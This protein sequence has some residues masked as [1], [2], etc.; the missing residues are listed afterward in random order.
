M[1]IIIRLFIGILVLIFGIMS[2]NICFATE[3]LDI[4]YE[5]LYLSIIVV[6]ILAIFSFVLDKA[7]LITTKNINSLP[8]VLLGFSFAQ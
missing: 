8:L 4:F 1:K 5:L 6:I 2:M 3:S 7:I